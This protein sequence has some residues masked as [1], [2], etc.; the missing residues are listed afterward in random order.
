MA[1][2]ASNH[3]ER[4]NI[5]SCEAHNERSEEYMKHIKPESVY[6]IQERTAFNLHWKSDQLK[7]KDLATYKQELVQLYKEKISQAPCEKD[8][9]VTNKKTGRKRTIAGWSPIRERVVN[10]KPTTTMEDLQRF[11]DACSQRF[12]F[13]PIRIDVHLDEGHITEEEPDVE[14]GEKYQLHDGR[15]VNLNLHAH[16][17]YDWVDHQT[18]KTYKCNENDMAEVQT[19]TA[20]ILGMERGKKKA[21]TGREHLKTEE[22]VAQKLQNKKDALTAD[23][24]ELEE[25]KA[26]KQEEVNN[27]QADL[28]HRGMGAL[29][30]LASDWVSG[31][32]A[33]KNKENDDIRKQNK[34]LIKER[35]EAQ[36]QARTADERAKAKYERDY[37]SEVENFKASFNKQVDAA[38][39]KKVT[40]NNKELADY[41]K[42]FMEILKENNRLAEVQV[43]N[44][45][46]KANLIARD[47]C[48]T[49]AL[50]LLWNIVA[51]FIEALRD[52][53]QNR[54]ISIW[55]EFTEQQVADMKRILQKF[56]DKPAE[57][58]KVAFWMLR[59]ASKKYHFNEEQE[60]QCKRELKRVLNNEYRIGVSGGYHKQ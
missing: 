48:A 55:S 42:Q 35:D 18:G 54:K 38:A 13:K 27:A 24:G 1:N 23:I 19:L 40:A 41:K 28:L 22:Y 33:K 8:R 4:C 36:E 58:E 9:E 5:G 3:I 16:I 57:Q 10:I 51:P 2:K 6:I 11:S 46:L 21:E 50:K 31:K 59:E 17:I 52:L 45:S 37:Q 43:E 20:E 60:K 44:Y 47:D 12:G 53:A 49:L 15:W 7:D 56:S 29:G 39:D 30:E 32:T 14:D 26:Q 25:K 34:Q